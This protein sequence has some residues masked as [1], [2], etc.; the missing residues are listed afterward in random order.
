MYPD[1]RMMMKFLILTFLQS[2]PVLILQVCTL[3]AGIFISWK[4]LARFFEKRVVF[5]TLLLVFFGTNLFWLTISGKIFPSGISIPDKFSFHPVNIFLV[6]FSFR[7]GWIIYTPLV[8]PAIAGFYFLAEKH[9]VLYVASFIFFLAGVMYTASQPHWWFND[10]FGYPGLAGMWVVLAIPLGYVVQWSWQGRPLKRFLLAGLAAML[11]LLNVFQ[12]WQFERSVI[13]PERMNGAYYLAIFGKIRAKPADRQKMDMPASLPID[14]IPSDADV[15]CSKI[16]G[17]DFE[18]SAPEYGAFQSD[19]VA[20]SGKYSLRMNPDFRFSPG[21]I[22]PIRQLASGD[23]AW[24]RASAWFYYT[25][26]RKSNVVFLVITSLHNGKPY[27]YKAT[28]LM[29]EQFSPG[30]WNEVSVSYLLPW[31]SNQQDTLHA[32]F[33]NYGNET[34]FIDDFEIELC[35]PGRPL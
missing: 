9:R 20:H 17:F 24:V 31:S 33:W 26:E 14:S 2:Y 6:L 25:C 3:I 7:N 35:K 22:M 30:R 28:E 1:A 27:R 8:L 13:I 19:R 34:C 32:F 12:T 21:L 16:L 11:M 15:T 5:V 4:I 10:S 29:G 18:Q 23:S